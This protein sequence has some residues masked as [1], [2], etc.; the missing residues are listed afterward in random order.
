MGNVW[1]SDINAVFEDFLKEE[2]E[3]GREGE[4]K[5]EGG[6]KGRRGGR[7]RESSL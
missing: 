6:K 4:G 1:N 3:E 5:K 2:R 7:R